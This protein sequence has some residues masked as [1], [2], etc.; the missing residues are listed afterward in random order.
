MKK[1]VHNWQLNMT[2]WTVLKLF[3][4]LNNLLEIWRIKIQI[5]TTNII[6]TSQR[7]SK[8]YI[9]TVVWLWDKFCNV[10]DSYHFISFQ[11]TNEMTLIGQM[12]FQGLM[13]F[14][15]CSSVWPLSLK[16]AAVTQWVRRRVLWVWFLLGVVVSERA[17]PAITHVLYAS[18]GLIG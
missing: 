2:T 15:H 17:F 3:P 7:K 6:E 16:G 14:D 1:D 13:I 8:P 11:R 12:T 18:L 4:P 9:C 5:N 10:S